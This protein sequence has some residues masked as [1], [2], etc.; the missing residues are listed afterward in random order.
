MTIPSS[1]FQDP[2]SVI[3]KKQFFDLGCGAC[4]CHQPKPDR[5]E[6][7]CIAGCKQ[8]PYGTN[9]SCGFFAKRKRKE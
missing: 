3:E 8:W 6:F 4:R 7:E 5:S 1:Q 2:S 9:R